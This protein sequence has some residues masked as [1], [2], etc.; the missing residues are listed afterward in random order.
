MDGDG[1]MIEEV[2]RI[3]KATLSY[4]ETKRGRLTKAFVSH[5]LA[6]EIESHEEDEKEEVERLRLV[7][8]NVFSIWEIAPPKETR[9]L[10]RS[11]REDEISKESC[12]AAWE[13]YR[14]SWIPKSPLLLHLSVSIAYYIRGMTSSRKW[15]TFEPVLSETETRDEIEKRFKLFLSSCTSID[16]ILN[17]VFHDMSILRMLLNMRTTEGTLRKRI[18]LPPIRELLRA[19]DAFHTT[20]GQSILSVGARALAK[21]CKRSKKGWWGTCEGSELKKNEDSRKL[22]VRMIRNVVWIN[23]HGLPHEVSVLEMRVKEGYGLRW[24]VR[25]SPE[26]QWTCIVDHFRGFLEPPMSDGH[27]K[28]WHH[29]K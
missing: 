6:R 16:E 15:H 4:C 9:S 17:T 5:L 22:A 24:A 14:T 18:M 28:G 8:T 13:A 1:V 11:I 3:A 26:P 10:Y 12:A 23:V 20:V 19:F 29:D 7:R 25:Y 21:H 2:F 27:E